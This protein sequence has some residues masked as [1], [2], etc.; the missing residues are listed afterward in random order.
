MLFGVGLGAVCVA[1][2]QWEQAITSALL[3]LRL[4]GSVVLHLEGTEFIQG[5]YAPVQCDLFLSTM[6]VDEKPFTQ[7]ELTTFLN[8]RLADRI[9]GDGT[10][11]W[12]YNNRTYEYSA[13]NYGAYGGKVSPNYNRDLFNMVH[14]SARGFAA[15]PARLI[16]EAFGGVTPE[17]RGWMPG[18]AGYTISGQQAYRDPVWPDR[19]YNPLATEQVWLFTNS[20]R[21]SLAFT[22]DTTTANE[23]TKIQ[24]CEA[25]RSGSQPRITQ[26]TMNVWK[27]A[28]LDQADFKPY[29]A[30]AIRGWH[31]ISGVRTSGS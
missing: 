4:S 21:R 15:Y 3:P 22:I 16:K 28:K 7:I 14:A 30:N 24:F 9:V 12:V 10:T 1:Q 18:L 13:Q 5:K 27:D 31:A 25:F 26:W 19:V 8:N 11:V 2:D 17:Y 20:V 23:V 6:I 29:P